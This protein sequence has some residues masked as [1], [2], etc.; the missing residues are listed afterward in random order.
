MEALEVGDRRRVVGQLVP[1]QRGR[2]DVR[3][4]RGTLSV[5]ADEVGRFVAHD[6]VPGPVS[7]HCA[8]TAG[9]GAITTD[10]VVI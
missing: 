1:P 4:R 10:W 9:E 8:G 2:I 5:T 3:H 7:L 6:V